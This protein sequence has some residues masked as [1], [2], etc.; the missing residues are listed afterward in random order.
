MTGNESQSRVDQLLALDIPAFL[1]QD[2]RQVEIGVRIVDAAAHH[3][4]QMLNGL[5]RFAGKQQPAT[6]VPL[7]FGVVRSHRGRA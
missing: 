7:N 6:D 5:F 2:P 1:E 3:V 4:A